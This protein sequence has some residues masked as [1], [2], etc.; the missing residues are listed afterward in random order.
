MTQRVDRGREKGRNKKWVLEGFVVPLT[1][2]G[3][4]SVPRETLLQQTV[5]NDFI[6]TDTNPHCKPQ[7]MSHCRVRQSMV[8]MVFS[9]KFINVN[10]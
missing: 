9:L 7:G 1:A 10:M 6:F 8:W 5:N 3:W 4:R 2:K